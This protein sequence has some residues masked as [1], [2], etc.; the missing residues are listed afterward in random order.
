MADYR[1]GLRSVEE[2]RTATLPVEGDLPPWLDGTLFVNGPGRFEVGDRALNHWFDGLALLRRFAIRDGAVEYAS[3]F[4]R[5]E[6]YEHAV[7]RGRLARGQF[8]TNPEP[9]L[10]NRLAWLFG[11]TLTDNAS[12]GVDWVGGEFVAVTETP[13]M[14]A[15]DPETGAT[16][17]TRTFADDLATTGSLGHP[18]WDPSRDEMVNLG[19]RYGLRSEYVLHRR[20]RGS[21]TREVVGRAETD[22]PSYVHSFAITE[23]YAVLAESPLV[24][25]PRALLGGPF[26][27]ALEWVPDR[28]TRW[29]VFDRRTGR[30]VARPV[31]EPFFVFHHV[32]AYEDGDELVVDLVAYEDASAV[33]DLSLSKLRDPESTLPAGELRRYRI[34]LGATGAS[35][36]SERL[37]PGP[38]EFPMFNYPRHNARP[39][40][41]AYFAG[42][43]E[44]P[45]ATTQDRL[46]KVDVA[47]GEEVGSWE[48][49]AC[50]P[51]EAVF[52]A[53]PGA[54][55]EDAGALLSVV[56]DADAERSFLLIAD[57]A[58]FDE[59]ARAPLPHALPFGF[60]G[61]FVRNVADPTR[62]MA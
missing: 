1:L 19:V 41:Y 49:A 39:Y 10:R 53:E 46:C 48:A 9:S 13:R 51:G 26:V 15:F 38:V 18:H 57:A 2:E 11:P 29:T 8:G 5:S 43:R 7:D 24:L 23:R 12:I 16:R 25:S 61:Q 20:K 14:V 47:A 44:R 22:R 50:Y 56:L 52:V 17:G 60:H 45:S 28:G 58:T 6:E 55:A 62:S 37:H 30:V 42:N 21:A 59:R 35:V 36:A 54:E 33:F 31:A 27:E 4:L 40:R 32:N 3:R 34:S